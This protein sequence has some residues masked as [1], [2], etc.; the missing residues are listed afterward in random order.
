MWRADRVGEWGDCALDRDIA[1]IVS[2]YD[3]DTAEEHYSALMAEARAG[4]GPT[5][6]TRETLPD[7]DGRY[8]RGGADQQ[9]IWGRNLQTSTMISLL[10]PEYRARMTQQS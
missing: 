10:T 7:W 6:H 4:G 3:Y 1:D 9:W 2:P 5:L 8:R